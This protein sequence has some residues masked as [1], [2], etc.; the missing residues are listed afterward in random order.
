MPD[1]AIQSPDAISGEDRRRESPDGTLLSAYARTR[2]EAAFAEILRRYAPLV[3][4]VC[5][6]LLRDAHDA[7]DAAQ[8]TF[9]ILSR[10]ATLLPSGTILSGWLHT[11]ARYSS[12]KMRRDGIIQRR[13]E[14]EAAM[15]R[16]ESAAGALD[17]A[18]APLSSA[19][20]EAL[21]RLSP[22]LRDAVLLHCAGGLSQEATAAELGCSVSAAS[23]R[24]ARGLE[25]LR[26]ILARRGAVVAPAAL[27]ALLGRAEAGE[28]P[29]EFLRQTL[30][31]CTSQGPIPAEM[32]ALATGAEAMMLWAKLKLAA[33]WTAAGLLAAGLLCG[34]WIAA[35][36]K[37]SSSDPDARALASL[38]IAAGETPKIVHDWPCYTGPDGTFADPSKVPLLDDLGKARL[39][40]ISEHE[41]LGYG[42]AICGD[43][44]GYGKNN[45]KPS[46]SASLIVAGGLLIAGYF[47][48]KNGVLADDIILALDAATGKTRWKQVFVNKGINRGAGLTSIFG[49]TPAA[50]DDKVFHL[51]TS[52]R[53]YC[54]ELTTGNPL[55]E[56][57][58]G[59]EH[60]LLEGIKAK[61]SGFVREQTKEGIGSHWALLPGASE[62]ARKAIATRAK[63]LVTPLMAIDGVLMVHVP[64][65][66]IGFDAATGIKLW[67]I[68]RATSLQSVPCAAKL[69][70]TLYVLC[71]GPD[72]FM[73]LVRPKT[74]DVVWKE[75]LGACFPPIVADGRAF[76]PRAKAQAEGQ[77]LPIGSENERPVLTAF[78]LSESGATLLW[79]SDF[80]MDGD[81][82]HAYRDGVLY[83][84]AHVF[85]KAGGK[86]RAYKAED[87]TLLG[88]YDD[89][90]GDLERF[91]VWGDRLVI[92]GNLHRESP[93]YPS[94]YWAL[95]PGVKDLSKSGRPLMPWRMTGCMGVFGEKVPVRDPFA[96]GFQFTRAF[97]I[98]KGRGVILCWDLRRNI[99]SGTA[100][101]RR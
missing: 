26:K 11:V 6:R 69:N 87:G 92:L 22:K 9:L 37:K 48:A 70:G 28:M 75:F 41:D 67:E 46:G 30:V 18:G 47:S 78:A 20:D 39:A 55:W 61:T 62:E 42:K 98:N 82:W 14:W 97:D 90:T 29:A 49:P 64:P 63:S 40:W 76:V 59:E 57:D 99:D 51:G 74:G 25:R 96:D 31:L 16:T 73:R 36:A 10:K 65:A 13:R 93:K 12:L 15:K 17:P 4:T 88:F 53:V 100:D 101:T 44:H 43:G 95:T 50:A 3:L 2:D 56:S 19:L 54:V 21:G 34:L 45:Y 91:H 66:L 8:A 60:T 33:G 83:A 52:G 7:E 24:I 32:L 85:Q 86:I 35:E 94:C 5:R 23:V 27:P 58:V 38:E 79:Q 68:A 84:C 71:S 81:A 80:P 89:K 1:M 77:D 72:G